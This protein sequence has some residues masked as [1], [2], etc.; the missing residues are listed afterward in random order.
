MFLILILFLFLELIS[1]PFFLLQLYAFLHFIA[2]RGCYT[3]PS[4]PSSASTAETHRFVPFL[5]LSKGFFLFQAS[6]ES[7][8]RLFSKHSS[9]NFVPEA[10]VMYSCGCSISSRHHDRASKLR[11][12]YAYN[13]IGIDL[14][15]FMLVAFFLFFYF[16]FPF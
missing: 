12:V 2:F 6:L 16:G 11:R 14:L 10:R 7:L 15:F 5:H 4:N 8:I 1:V 13:F 3:G 9:K